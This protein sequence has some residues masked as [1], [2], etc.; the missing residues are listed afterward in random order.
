MID[1][2]MPVLFMNDFDTDRTFFDRFT[3]SNEASMPELLG[4]I[5]HSITTTQPTKE[6][7]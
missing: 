1:A 7:R 3:T 4:A 6:G 5:R 2:L